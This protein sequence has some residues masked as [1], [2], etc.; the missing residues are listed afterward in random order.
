MDRNASTLS[1][2]L[3]GLKEYVMG[4]DVRLIHWKT[5]SRTQGLFVRHREHQATLPLV[6]IL[7]CEER[8][9]ADED[10]FDGAA[11]LIASMSY[12]STQQDIPCKL[13]AMT[14]AIFGNPS[15]HHG[16]ARS[17]TTRKTC[18][19]TAGQI[20]CVLSITMFVTVLWRNFLIAILHY[21]L[22]RR[23][24]TPDTFV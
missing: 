5:S 4:D 1:D 3:M 6:I 14:M 19:G 24:I 18:S 9:F 11:R 8:S 10:E 2:D 12:A 20:D 17:Y 23:H 16:P 22:D 7:D 13:S 21:A 15:S